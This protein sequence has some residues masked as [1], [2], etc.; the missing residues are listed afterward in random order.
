[1]PPAVNTYDTSMG[2]AALALASSWHSSDIM[3]I[4]TNGPPAAGAADLGGWDTEQVRR[5]SL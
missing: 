1:M 5:L 3:G 4:G 2:D